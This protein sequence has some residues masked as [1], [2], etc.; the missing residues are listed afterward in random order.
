MTCLSSGFNSFNEDRSEIFLGLD[1]CKSQSD[2]D[3]KC[4]WSHC[5]LFAKKYK[6]DYYE[7]EMTEHQTNSRTPFVIKIA[8]SDFNSKVTLEIIK[9]FLFGEVDK[10]ILDDHEMFQAARKF[11]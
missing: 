6:C 7:I 1:E 11:E 5:R 10:D 9:Y 3:A 4:D 8:K 2:G